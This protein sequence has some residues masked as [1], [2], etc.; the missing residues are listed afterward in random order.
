MNDRQPMFLL[1]QMVQF[2]NETTEG[3]PCP[4]VK[5][6]KTQPENVKTQPAKMGFDPAAMR[7]VKIW[8]G[9][10]QGSREILEHAPTISV[11]RGHGWDNEDGGEEDTE[12][13]PTVEGI[14]IG[15]AITPSVKN[16]ELEY[17]LQYKGS[18]GSD[19]ERGP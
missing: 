6:A 12:G 18:L 2:Q 17:G 5:A 19:R 7:D 8:S 13:E 4:H 15:P 14:R 11:R 16:H 3:K 10:D 9:A 1:G